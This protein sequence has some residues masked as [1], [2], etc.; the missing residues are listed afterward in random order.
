MERVGCSGREGG[1]CS[2]ERGRRSS[3]S[4]SLVID[5]L[6]CFSSLRPA[7]HL[8]ERK[9][10]TYQKRSQ[11]MCLKSSKRHFIFF[12]K[13]CNSTLFWRLFYKVHKHLIWQSL[14]QCCANYTKF[15]T[16]PFEFCSEKNCV[17]SAHLL[18]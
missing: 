16:H 9:T 6:N 15:T 17:F 2:G 13:K 18:P 7:F 11:F 3:G 14:R 1:C 4:L 5:Q 8:L 12:T 10:I